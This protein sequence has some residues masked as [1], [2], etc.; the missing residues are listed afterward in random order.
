MSDAGERFWC[1]A[2]ERERHGKAALRVGRF[3]ICADCAHEIQGQEW[4]VSWAIGV[5]VAA[6]RA[7]RIS[8]ERESSRETS[9]A[10]REAYAQGRDDGRNESGG[11]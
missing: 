8:A 6:S 2:C 10:A 4:F 5:M 3:S 1:L 9:I 11:W 7:A